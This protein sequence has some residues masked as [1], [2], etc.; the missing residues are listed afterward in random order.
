MSKF[1][2]FSSGLLGFAWVCSGL[3]GFAGV[4]SGLPCLLGFAVGLH[5][6][7]FY[8]SSGGRAIFFTGPRAG[9]LFE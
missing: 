9:G 6:P 3:L 8:R 1:G 5:E 4:C 2:S 7:A